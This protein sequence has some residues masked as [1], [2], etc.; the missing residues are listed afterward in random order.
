MKL[1]LQGI[2]IHD[3]L[4]WFKLK[5]ENSSDIDFESEN[6]RFSVKDKHSGKRTAVQETDLSPLWRNPDQ[7]V[8]GQSEQDFVFAFPSFTINKHKKLLIQ[9]SE[10]NGER[11]LI[12]EIP[13]Q[14]NSK[15]SIYLII[16]KCKS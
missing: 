11:Q 1:I 13:A 3:H 12:L 7:K 15:M 10:K 14:D 4:L 6:I 16:I 2:Y 9:I 5:L 8:A